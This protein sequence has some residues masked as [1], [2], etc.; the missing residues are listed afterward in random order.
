[1]RS[2]SPS[3]DNWIHRHECLNCALYSGCAQKGEI[4]RRYGLFR[5]YRTYKKGE[6]LR[7]FRRKNVYQSQVA[8]HPSLAKHWAYLEPLPAIFLVRR[9]WRV[10]EPSLGGAE[11]GVLD[12]EIRHI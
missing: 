3:V 9:P 8:L 6:K 5:R 12:L 7:N 1:M 10:G 2:E 4:K 11:D